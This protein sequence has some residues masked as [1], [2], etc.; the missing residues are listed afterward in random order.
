M[1]NLVAQYAAKLNDHE[2]IAISLALKYSLERYKEQGYDIAGSPPTSTI[3]M[4][5]DL[6][7]R[8]EAIRLGNRRGSDKFDVKM[9]R[10]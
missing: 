4:Q 8:I 6:R 5:R 7:E 9:V 10:A 2:M 1:S 3:G